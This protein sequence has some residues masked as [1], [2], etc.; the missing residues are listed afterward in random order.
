MPRSRHTAICSIRSS[1]RIQVSAD[2]PE[3]EFLQCA[4]LLHR[5]KDG[6]AR[7]V[8]SRG[9]SAAVWAVD[10]GRTTAA[11]AGMDGQVVV[12]DLGSGRATKQLSCRPAG[13]QWP[14]VWA[15]GAQ[16]GPMKP[17]TA[18][19]L[20]PAAAAASAP[21]GAYSCVRACRS[22]HMLQATGS[23]TAQRGAPCRQLPSRLSC[24]CHACASVPLHL[25]YRRCCHA[26]SRC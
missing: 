9:H 3:P 25:S 2:T 26:S 5:G 8:M 6:T 21:A 24:C 19:C 16:V 20:L 4:V 18:H 17:A 1:P 12:W 14:R 11:S 23:A 7:Y 13:Q 10:A 22:L 15:T